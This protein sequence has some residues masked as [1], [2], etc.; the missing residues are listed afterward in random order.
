M[1][2]K[3]NRKILAPSVSY[4]HYAGNKEFNHQMTRHTIAKVKCITT[5][6]GFKYRIS[7]IYRSAKLYTGYQIPGDISRYGTKY[8]TSN[9]TSYQMKNIHMNVYINHMKLLK[10]SLESYTHRRYLF[11]EEASQMRL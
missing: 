9:W 8:R 4:I 1:Y 3:W 2:P 10:I 5:K 6:Q 11:F 7:V